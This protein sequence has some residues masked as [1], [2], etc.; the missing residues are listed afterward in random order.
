[1]RVRLPPRAHTAPGTGHGLSRRPFQ[2]PRHRGGGDTGAG[3][4]RFRACP[5]TPPDP[6]TR[7]TPPTRPALTA[8]A[9]RKTR[10]WRLTGRPSTWR[11]TCRRSRPL[12]R[13]ARWLRGSGSGA[14]CAAVGPPLVDVRRQDRSP[15]RS[16]VPAPL[17]EPTIPGTLVPCSDPAAIGA[18][19]LDPADA[20]VGSVELGIA[21]PGG[22]LGG[23]PVRH[24]PLAGA[25]P[26]RAGPT[27][28][29]GDPGLL[30]EVIDPGS[31]TAGRR[32]RHARGAIAAAGRRASEAGSGDPRP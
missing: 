5:S 2:C 29:Q 32:R 22:P 20:Q 15:A 1:M 23:L 17:P 25:H 8:R 26:A 7:A 3:G 6:P 30:L 31:S 24:E 10:S 14:S 21:E 19:I 27:D 18:S 13:P 4:V 11:Y 16:P 28:Q 12:S 9:T